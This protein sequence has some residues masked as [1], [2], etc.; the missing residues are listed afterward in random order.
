[1][2]TAR[3][4]VL[5]LALLVVAP[6]AGAQ[7]SAV[8]APTGLHGFLL[9]A[10]EPVTDSFSRTPSFAWNPVAGATQYQFQLST[11]STFRENGLIWNASGLSSPVVA[12]DIS[13][14]WITGNPH[15]LYARVRAQ[16]KSGATPWSA[17]FGFDMEPAT[18]P[19]PMPTYN[20]LL[21]WTPVDGANEYQIWFVDVPK[22]ET[23]NT[24]VIDERELYTFHHDASWTGTV[25]W[26]VRALRW[27]IDDK[28]DKKLNSIPEAGYGP[29]SPVYTT[30]NGAFTDGPITLGSTVSD[31]ISDG[32][33]SSPAHDITPGFT[34]S[35]DIGLGGAKAELFRVYVFTDRECLNRVFTG[36]VV[37]GPAYAPRPH[38]PL[39]LP[40]TTDALTNARTSFLTADG[41][42]P[43]GLTVDGTA[44]QTT[45]SLPA[46]T[47]TTTVPADSD[48]DSSGG[49]TSAD[50]PPSQLDV[51][52]DLGAP[53][54]LWD[55][56]WPEGGYYWTVVPVAAISPGA[57]STTV[58]GATLVGTITLPVTSGTGFKV[59]DSV[60]I[61]S[62]LTKESAT[63]TDVSAT[64]L[65]LSGAL[66]YAHAAG[67]TV[68]RPG[69]NLEYVDM[70]LAQDACAAGRVARFGKTSQPSLT[71]EG[72]TFASGLS[73]SGRLATG[74]T[75]PRFYGSPLVAWTPAVGADAYEIQWSKTQYPFVPEKDPQSQGALGRMTLGTS[76]V[77]PLKPGV[78]YYRVRG[79]SFTL[80][81]GAQQLSWSD[82]VRIVV[83]KPRFRVVGGGK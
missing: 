37:G 68:N 31:T 59:G 62:G 65:T 70:E 39:S 23:V 52:G 57:L 16:F 64:T 19:V 82:P 50:A 51:K 30:S 13:L 79:F 42:E 41:P 49:T 11:S 2:L 66:K 69:G 83:A 26:R 22:I 63:I 36:A 76:A 60:T 74:A 6:S 77:L 8:K 17:A 25:H 24:N 72:G 18:A 43:T 56:A 44:L 40:T 20:G 73:A 47:P 21:R 38:G 5:C 71:A 15:A 48:T 14:P 10:N 33:A 12:P 28:N 45:E 58:S 9:R 46:A 55:T 61:G 4:V 80:P 75:S 32:S 3:I 78:W 1:M 53:V 81:T 35:G 67:E 7:S 29:W 54:D 34:W 27:F